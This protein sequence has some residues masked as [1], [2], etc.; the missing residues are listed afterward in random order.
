MSSN[1]EENEQKK[2]STTVPQNTHVDASPVRDIKA[3]EQQVDLKYFELVKSKLPPEEQ[4]K[5]QESAPQATATPMPSPSQQT[6]E[7]ASSH[8]RT[9]QEQPIQPQENENKDASKDIFELPLFD[10]SDRREENHYRQTNT[11]VKVKKRLGFGRRVRKTKLQLEQYADTASQAVKKQDLR[12]ELVFSEDTGEKLGV[13]T[14]TVYDDDHHVI[15][16]K[17]KTDDATTAFSFPA[18]QF[19]EEKQGMLLTSNWYRNALETIEKLELYEKISPE[20]NSL[21]KDGMFNEQLYDLLLKRDEEFGTDLDDALLLK[22]IILSQIQIL[23][24]RR[25]DL[26]EK[27]QSLVSKR[28]IE[29]VDRTE[30]SADVQKLRRNV[31]LLDLNIQKCDTLLRR[32][33]STSIGVITDYV[34]QDEEGVSEYNREHDKKHS[35][36]LEKTS[37]KDLDD[38][39]TLAELIGELIEEI[40]V[41]D[42]KKQLR[43]NKTSHQDESSEHG[44]DH[45]ASSHSDTDEENSWSQ[46]RQEL[47]RKHRH[48]L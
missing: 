13:I 25:S 8:V 32:L 2:H 31:H 4:P 18:E 7:K 6:M 20:L 1:E 14:E 40:L 21:V 39:P 11:P 29:D 44:Q 10:E 41:D 24:E 38:D 3:I 17:I 47:L 42:I 46:R 48:H 34:T 43:R 26:S 36:T 23:E 30:F 35:G 22:E 37:G 15:G 19:I 27:A 45:R 28:L 12:G 9:A 33:I 16:Y 5:N